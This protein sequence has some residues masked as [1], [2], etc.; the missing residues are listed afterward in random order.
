MEEAG[1]GKG[2]EEDG[3]RGE[4]GVTWDLNFPLFMWM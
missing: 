1:C 3:D 4:E 2:I